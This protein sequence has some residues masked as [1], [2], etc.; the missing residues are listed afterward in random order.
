MCE[1]D[2]KERGVWGGGVCERGVLR[3]RCV[4]ERR[5]RGVCENIMGGRCGCE[6][7]VKE[8]GVWG[9]CVCVR[10][11][12]ERGVCKRGGQEVCVSALCVGIVCV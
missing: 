5:T 11:A 6:R 3:K 2:V 4:W 10:G 1:T 9:R 7:D 8:R 12:R